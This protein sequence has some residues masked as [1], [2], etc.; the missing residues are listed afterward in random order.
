MEPMQWFTT[1]N[2]CPTRSREVAGNEF[3][4]RL[5]FCAEEYKEI[6]RQLAASGKC[7]FVL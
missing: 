7:T 1:A 4:V 5:G 3:C 6:V 2:C